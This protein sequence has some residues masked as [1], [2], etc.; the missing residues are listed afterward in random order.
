MRHPRGD[1][2][3]RATGWGLS[4]A[5]GSGTLKLDNCDPNC[6][7]GSFTDYQVTVVLSDLTGYGGGAAYATM[8]VVAPGSPFG[9]RTYKHLAP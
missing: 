1:L 7:Q 8:M 2:Q 9:T 6:A 3:W 5:T 4:G